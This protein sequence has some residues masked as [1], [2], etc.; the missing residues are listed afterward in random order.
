MY[1]FD[2]QSEFHRYPQGGIM[3]GHEIQ[4]KV[5]VKKSSTLVPSIL[6]EKR[7]NYDNIF[8]SE[9]SMKWTGTEKGYDLYS[10]LF[11]IDKEG[12]YFY[13]FVLKDN[14]ADINTLESIH[15]S[16]SQKYEL[17]IHSTD[18][19]TP[20]WIS[21]G[22]IYHIFV[23]RFYR[24]ITLKKPHPADSAIEIRNDWGGTPHYLPDE[25][26]EIKNNDFFGGNLK[27][28]EE[29][30]PYL[31]E[32]GVTVLYLSPI[33][34]A[35]SNHKYDTGDYFTIDPMFGDENSLTDLCSHAE[36]LGIHIILDGVF[37][38]TG[39][40]SIYFNKY[41][42]YSSTGAYQ[43]I[44][45]PYYDWYFFNRWNDDYESWW[46]IPTLPTVNKGCKN[47]V[48][49][50]AGK[51]GVLNHWQKK[52]I[53]GWRLDVADE[54]PD[55]FLENLRNSVKSRDHEAFIVG[56][57]WEDAS[58]KFS[59]GILKKYFLGNQLDSVTNYPLKDAIIEYVITGDCSILNYTINYII[60]KY[61]PQT[62]SC[63]MNILGTHD[64]ARILTV[65]G[66]EKTPE[67]RIE[68]A[69][70]NLNDKEKQKGIQLLKIA[71]LLQFTLPGIP[72]IYYG[73][74]AGVEG[75]EDP[76]N[77][78]CFPWGNENVEILNHY[79]FL[80]VLRKSKLFS[81]GKY[82]NVINDKEIFAFERYDECERI[83]IAANMSEEDVT[84][85]IAESMV[86]YSSGKTGRTFTL[87][88]KDFLILSKTT[89]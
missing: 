59:Y 32:L 4:L 51:N 54:L 86:Q 89:K 77:R 13:S 70:Y 47:Y 21:G 72:C 82:K 53:K 37:S 23:D 65:L 41:G 30:L 52:G 10:C 14:P 38:H 34:D 68:R 84:L 7:N 73:D 56:E 3:C 87:N 26:G 40:D 62:I 48:D 9:I 8:Y 5:Y 1:I 11:T 76:F 80:S 61:P 67:S 66:S 16:S 12:H 79:K 49:F 15:I 19:S 28:I 20:K 2:N 63:L 46:R 39:A 88:S 22:I 74:E 24:T 75:F 29:K 27:G 31:S 33:F 45:S 81:N 25:N 6:I 43:S 69:E 44:H 42:N 57:V 18:Y 50:I 78:A 83:I 36:K 58:N 64:T 35:Y 71:S 55:D 17:I 60:E 85:N